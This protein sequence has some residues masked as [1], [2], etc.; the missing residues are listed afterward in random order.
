M[1]RGIEDK[2]GRRKEEMKEIEEFKMKGKRDKMIKI[3]IR[4]KD[5]REMEE[6]L[7]GKFIKIIKW[8]WGKDKEK[9][10]WKGER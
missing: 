2:E 8:M 1:N 6:K 9:K 5:K 3:R 7:N 4:R 10:S